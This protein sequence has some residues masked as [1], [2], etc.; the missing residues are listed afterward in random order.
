MRVWL[1]SPESRK[2]AYL[3]QEG[4]DLPLEVEKQL[5]SLEITL[6]H[7]RHEDM[8]TTRGL[9]IFGPNDHR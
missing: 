9:N 4:Y 2:I 6:Q 7:V 8:P 3:A 1:K 5:D